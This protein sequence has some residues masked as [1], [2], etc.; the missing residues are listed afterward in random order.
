MAGTNPFDEI[1]RLF[2]TSKEVVVQFEIPQPHRQPPRTLLVRIT[3]S[4]S[5][6][7]EALISNMDNGVA[8]VVFNKHDSSWGDI[9][10]EIAVHAGA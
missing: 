10:K 7:Y 8:V 3:G 2:P 6:G 4:A 1:T 9:V 5:F